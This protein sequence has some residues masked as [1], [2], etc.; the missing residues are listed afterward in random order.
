MAPELPADTVSGYCMSHF[1]RN[2]IADP[3]TELPVFAAVEHQMAV[4]GGL[5]PG[6]QAPEQ[7]I[8]LERHGELHGNPLQTVAL[9]RWGE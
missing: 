8:L 9:Y 2:R 6:I 4:C 7:M 1:G 5:A 3:V